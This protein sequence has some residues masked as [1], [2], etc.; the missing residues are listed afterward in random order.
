M[1]QMSIKKFLVF[2][3]E[4]TRKMPQEKIR[5]S[6]SNRGEYIAYV[7]KTKTSTN[8]DFQ[9]RVSGRG[10]LRNISVVAPDLISAK[11]AFIEARGGGIVWQN[12]ECL[13]KR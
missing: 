7:T 1:S 4:E 9:Y 10:T 6:L 11:N 5:G 2:S 12:E 8:F 13:Q 3:K